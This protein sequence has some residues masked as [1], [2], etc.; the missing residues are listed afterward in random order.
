MK[1]SIIVRECGI[2]WKKMYEVRVSCHNEECENYIFNDNSKYI[3]KTEFNRD[4]EGECRLNKI[5]KESVNC[6]FCNRKGEVDVA[7]I[8]VSSK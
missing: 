3:Y 5:K 8:R 1:E 7:N 4:D 2:D 6:P